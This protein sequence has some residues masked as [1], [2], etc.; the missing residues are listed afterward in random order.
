MKCE[1]STQEEYS[2]I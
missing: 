1:N 2:Q